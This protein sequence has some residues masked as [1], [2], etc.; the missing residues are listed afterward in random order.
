MKK[1]ALAIV[2]LF[3]CNQ[4]CT[5]PERTQETLEGAGY[6]E[7]EITGYSRGSCGEGDVT[8]TGF[9]AIGPTGKPVSGAVG[10][11]RSGCGK[12]CTIRFD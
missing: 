2:L 12:G 1:F 9:T 4:S 7:I 3:S 5:N 10:C 11:G 8:C 6:R